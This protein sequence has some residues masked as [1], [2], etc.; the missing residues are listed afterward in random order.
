M[1]NVFEKMPIAVKIIW[2]AI[3]CAI[4]IFAIFQATNVT[5]LY[6]GF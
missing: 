3:K 5:V 6:Q 4:V 2:I 1:N